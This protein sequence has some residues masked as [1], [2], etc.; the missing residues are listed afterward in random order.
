[1]PR[2]D[3]TIDVN[4]H[5]PSR[6][7]LLVGALLICALHGCAIVTLP[8]PWWHGSVRSGAAVSETAT[9]PLRVDETSRAEVLDRLGPP[10]RHFDE[11]R[12]DAYGW[13]DVSWYF[14]WLFVMYFP[15]VQGMGL[16]ER[17]QRHIVVVRYDSGD[18]VERVGGQVCGGNETIGECVRQWVEE[19]E[20][21]IRRTSMQSNTVVFVW[22]PAKWRWGV[23]A[24]GVDVRIDGEL[25]AELPPRTWTAVRAHPG[26]RVITLTSRDEPPTVGQG[27]EWAVGTQ[28]QPRPPEPDCKGEESFE[29]RLEAG[30]SY[31]IEVG[32]DQTP[33]RTCGVVHWTARTRAEGID[34]RSQLR[35]VW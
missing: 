7:L 4:R 11:L 3:T 18:R 22:N 2:G 6:I 31:E 33:P 10:A 27:G 9:A 13:T 12:I 25:V 14:P 23:V 16:A 21:E 29:M 26:V 28:P 34:A 19:A 30:L 32:S 5:P 17:W 15:P 1:M 8:L 24:A 35:E 20:P